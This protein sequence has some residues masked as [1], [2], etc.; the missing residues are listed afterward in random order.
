MDDVPLVRV[1][2]LRL[3]TVGALYHGGRCIIIDRDIARD[4]DAFVDLILA[5]GVTVLNQT[6][7]AFYQLIDARTRSRS[8]DRHGSADWPLR[9]IVFGGEALN[10]EHV[11]RWFDLFPADRARL[12]NMYG[13][14]ETTVRQLPRTGPGRG[15]GG[16]RILIGRRWLPSES[17]SSTSACGPYRWA[18][19][20][21]V[22]LRRATRAGLPPAH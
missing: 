18:W 1:R 13:I 15:V 22:R 4:T 19:W 7:S 2:L 3:G 11:R 8:V 6:P 12:V 21:D 16:G 17:P 5:Q 20:A 14:T 10:F 9:Y